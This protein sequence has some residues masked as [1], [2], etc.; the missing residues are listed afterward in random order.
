MNLIEYTL[1]CIQARED[2]RGGALFML[3]S[4][5]IPKKWIFAALAVLLSVPFL[6]YAA[7]HGTLPG[8][9]PYF[10]PRETV[11]GKVFEMDGRRYLWGGENVDEHFD[12]TEFR[13][14]PKRLEYGLGREAIPSLIAPAFVDLAT[15]NTALGDQNRVLVA[16]SGDEVKIYPLRWLRYNEVV[17]DTLGGRPILVAYCLLAN[18]AAIYERQIGDTTYTFAASGYTYYDWRVWHG[19]SAFVLWDRETESL[20]WPPIGKGVSGP[21]VDVPMKLLDT[22]SW[23]QTTWG[24]A[25]AAFPN[26]KVLKPSQKSRVPETWPSAEPAAVDLAGNKGP[27]DAI[28]PYWGENGELPLAE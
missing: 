15:L 11:T 7:R 3:K 19:Y 4:L 2:Q 16:R 24:A 26:A 6:Q 27:R 23:C 20:W 21:S 8:Y 1:C 10:M 22:S 18:L 13:L 9:D 17:N 14:N 25:V 28:A 5:P 12:I